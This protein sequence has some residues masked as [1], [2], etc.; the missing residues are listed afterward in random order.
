MQISNAI[1][2]KLNIQTPWGLVRPIFVPKGVG[3]ASGILQK[4]VMDIFSDYGS[5]TIA[6]FDNLLI[7]AH[8]Y[9]DTHNKFKIMIQR[10]N[11]RHVVLKF[12]K[13]WLG[14]DKVTFF[15]YLVRKRT[16]E[17]S[18]DRKQAILNII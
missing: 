5:W 9:E 11:E 4:C 18:E 7:L 6:I 8:S 13:S 12:S 3:P 2:K 10:C 14:L 15:G 1:S 16:F 17:M